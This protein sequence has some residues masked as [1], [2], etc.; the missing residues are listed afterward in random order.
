MKLES[1]FFYYV[2]YTNRGGG[3]GLQL[4]ESLYNFGEVEILYE[5]IVV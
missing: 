1:Y 5:N 3:M 2:M 4:M